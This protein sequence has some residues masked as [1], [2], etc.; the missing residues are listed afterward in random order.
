V[1]KPLWIYLTETWTKINYYQLQFQNLQADAAAAEAESY[2]STVKD[3][4]YH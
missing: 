4:G 1:E 2:A 3:E